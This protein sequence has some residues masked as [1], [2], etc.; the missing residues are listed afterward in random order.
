MDTLVAE[1]VNA[2]TETTNSQKK[3]IPPKIAGVNSVNNY[4]D[5][6]GIDICIELARGVDGEEMI[7]TLLAKTRLEVPITVQFAALNAKQLHLYSLRQYLAEYV[8]FQHEIV[9]NEYQLKLEELNR[10]AEILMGHIIAASYIDEIV[11]V[12]KHAENRAQIEDVLMHGTI[13]PGT[14]KAY[15]KTVKTFQFTPLQAEAISGR[16]L[17]QLNK[18]DTQKLVKEGQEIQ[19]AQEIARRMVED[20]SYRH[21]EIIRRLTEEQKKLPDTPRRTRII[22]DTPAK[23]SEA[24][25]PAVDLYVGMDHYGY[26]RIEGSPFEGAQKTDSKSR[27]GFF[28]E[29]GNCWNLFLDLVKETKGRGTLLSQLIEGLTSCVGFTTEIRETGDREG[30]FLFSDGALRRIP[31]KQY[32]T[33]TR[34]TKVKTQMENQAGCFL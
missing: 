2:T 30:L 25:T 21:K 26:V 3:K 7:Q 9:T 31:M 8:D 6:N 33:K 15:Q 16:Q 32:W 11:D 28:D 27:V 20:R 29:A 23:A 14:K 4:S 17:Y 1:L 22:S 10:R 19:K 5:K 18:L 13:L 24:E 34:A 12:V